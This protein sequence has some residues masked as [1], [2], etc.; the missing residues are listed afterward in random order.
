LILSIGQYR[1]LHGLMTMFPSL[2][3]KSIAF[4]F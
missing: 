2:P 1:E 4:L 3:P